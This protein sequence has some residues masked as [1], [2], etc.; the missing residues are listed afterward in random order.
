M[1]SRPRVIPFNVRFDAE[2]MDKN[3][4]TKLLAELPGILAWAVRGCL[5][6]QKEGLGTPEIVRLATAGYQK[7]QDPLGVFIDETTTYSKDFITLKAQLYR[8]Y[9]SWCKR[10]GEKPLSQRKLSSALLSHGWEAGEI[11]GGKRIWKNRAILDGIE[12]DFD[13]D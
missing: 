10:N 1:W 5:A 2:T 4:K 11:H 6:W 9:E 13:H 7:D 3:L 12:T 8:I